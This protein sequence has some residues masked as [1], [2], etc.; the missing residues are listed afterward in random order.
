MWSE[1]SDAFQAELAKLAPMGRYGRPDE[2]A[3][4]VAYLAS[5]AASFITGAVIDANGGVFG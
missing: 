3:S 4:A 1:H 2:I 5:E